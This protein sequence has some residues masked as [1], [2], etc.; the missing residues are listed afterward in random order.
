MNS[1]S[2]VFQSSRQGSSLLVNAIIKH[3]E[4]CLTDHLAH[5]ERVHSDVSMYCEDQFHQSL[6]SFLLYLPSVTSRAV[7]RAVDFHVSGFLNVLPL[8]YHHFELS[9]QEFRDALCLRYHRPLSLMPA[10]CDGCGKDSSL[11][12]ALDC[13][14]GGLVTQRHNKIRDALGDLAAL[15]YIQ[16]SCSGTPSE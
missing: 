13:R 14:K 12:H 11:T 10:R 15:G 9:A 16:G 7:W 3:E 1:A 2:L 8:A 4:V 5:L 6:S